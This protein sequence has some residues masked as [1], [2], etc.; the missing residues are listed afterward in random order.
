MKKKLLLLACC[1]ITVQA[2]TQK[3]KVR[4]VANEAG[5]RVDV[6]MNGKPFTSFIYPDALEKPVLYPIQTA[7][8]VTITRG[9]PLATRGIERNDHP[10][11]IGLWFNYE[12]VNGLDFWNNSYN[13]PAANKHR[14][15]W[16]RHVTVDTIQEGNTA[17]RLCYTAS[18][19]SQARKVLLKEQ[20]RFVFSGNANTRAIERVTTLT[21]RGDSVLLK[22]VKDGL[23]A[24]RV[25]GELEIPYDKQEPYI[26]SAGAV[27]KRTSA[28]NGANGT[29]ITSAGK[30]GDEAWGTRA[31]WCMLHGVKEGQPVSIAIIDHPANPGYPAYWH[32]R[33]YGLFAVNPLGQAVFSNNKEQLQLKLAPGQSVTFRYLVLITSKEAVTPAMLDKQARQFAGNSFSLP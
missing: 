21:A 2:F 25:A 4:F 16:I 3:A 30:T 22:D 31:S 32:A 29:Y 11:H 10:H 18:W 5:Q 1:A 7:G 24:I 17:G 28:S 8:G 20:T 12:S 27:T 6:L 33:G 9:F 15:G 13:I 19:E 23:L 14:Y 26:D